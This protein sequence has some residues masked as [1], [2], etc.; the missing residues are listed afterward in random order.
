S[1]IS[2]PW[3][4]RG[5][6]QTS[7]SARTGSQRRMGSPFAARV[8]TLPRDGRQAGE[9]LR[10]RVA[11]SKAPAAGAWSGD[12]APTGAD[13]ARLPT[14]WPSRHDTLNPRRGKT[15]DSSRG[16]IATLPG[17][18][19]AVGG[20]SADRPPGPDRRSP[21]ARETCGRPQGRGPETTPQP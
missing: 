6:D 2:R 9:N 5:P 3:A 20:R 4:R 17:G 10:G 14:P 12:H 11:P 8:R 7:R 16:E 18:V 21:S 19:G 13:L 15:S 1:G